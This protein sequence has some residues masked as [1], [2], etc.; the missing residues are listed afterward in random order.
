MIHYVLI[1]VFF[2]FE[3]SGKQP[4]TG[5]RYTLKDLEILKNESDFEDFFLHVNDIRPSLRNDDW[6][7]LVDEMA[8]GWAKSAKSST[9]FELSQFRQM[10]EIFN[11]APVKTNE[12][13]KQIRNS[14]ALSFFE[15]NFQTL[16]DNNVTI[17]L[18]DSYWKKDQ[19]SY[20]TG[21]EL[22]KLVFNQT[23]DIEKAW[24]FGS[25]ALKSQQGAFYCQKKD[26]EP[27]IFLKLA[28]TIEESALPPKKII[29]K[30]ID[31]DCWEQLKPIAKNY[32]FSF[33]QRIRGVYLAL[34]TEEKLL[35]NEENDLYSFSYLMEGPIQ[36]DSMNLAWNTVNDLKND[37][38]RRD[39]LLSKL[40]ARPVLPDGVLGAFD[41]DRKKI[42]VHFVSKSFPEYFDFY[43]RTCIQYLKGE[44]KFAEGNPTLHCKDLFEMNKKDHEL[45]TPVLTFQYQQSLKI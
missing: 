29:L 6:R 14:L 11:L 32:F 40:Q 10:E 22:L 27:L 17:G 9:T 8:L 15:K 30:T 28:R 18:I 38:T 20:E 1:L 36:G 2:I 3:A 16:E 24:N 39:T 13:F 21:L 42:I 44:V 12:R 41:Q 5:L 43:A 31:K 25:Q 26:I 35:T 34:L 45:V 7:N 33:P 23:N 19:T 37:K 4:T